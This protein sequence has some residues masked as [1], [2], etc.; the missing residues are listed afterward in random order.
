MAC[1]QA[2]QYCRLLNMKNHP[3]EPASSSADGLGHGSGPASVRAAGSRVASPASAA[4]GSGPGGSGGVGAGAGRMLLL[5]VGAG[6]GVV[7]EPSAGFAGLLRKRVRSGRIGGATELLIDRADVL[8][9]DVMPVDGR[10]SQEL[11]RSRDRSA[12]M[13][14]PSEHHKAHRD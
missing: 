12:H 9:S 6:G 3:Q 4:P 13:L 7:G 11:A 2:K 8:R 5:A 10:A 14:I 1:L